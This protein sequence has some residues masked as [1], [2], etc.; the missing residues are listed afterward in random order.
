M[1]NYVDGQTPKEDKSGRGQVQALRSGLRA[2]AARNPVISAS[3]D[4]LRAVVHA[5][6]AVVVHSG[7]ETPG[8]VPHAAVV[9]GVVPVVGFMYI[10]FVLKNYKLFKL[11]SKHKCTA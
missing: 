1:H 5:H 10:L 4:G 6:A 2:L 9:L 11:I 7:G 8:E 3:D